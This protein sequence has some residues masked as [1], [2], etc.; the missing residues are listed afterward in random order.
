MSP[1]P[2]DDPA[3]PPLAR[4]REGVESIELRRPGTQIWVTGIT[5]VAVDQLNRMIV[6]LASSLGLAVVVIVGVMMIALRSVR[7]GLVTVVPNVFP[8]AVTAAFLVWS[9]R[10]LELTSVVV[11]SVCLGIAVDDTIHFIMRYRRELVVD[12]D[13]GEAL[14]RTL[15]AVGAALLTTTAVLVG[16]FAVV[17]LS[18]IPTMRLFSTLACLALLSA[19]VGDL[20]FLPALL[21]WWDGPRLSRCSTRRHEPSEQ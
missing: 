2:A 19:L 1:N 7:L 17:Q 11:F 13:V 16:G 9:G 4:I 6:D 20:I 21:T 18:E 5:V 3:T 12:G 8:L 14:G 10:R 15:S